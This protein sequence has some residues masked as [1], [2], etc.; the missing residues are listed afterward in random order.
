VNIETI[1]SIARSRRVELF[2]VA[3]TRRAVRSL[4]DDRA[5]KHGPVRV[6]LARAVLGLGDICYVL[7]SALIPN[8]K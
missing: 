5:R 2:E 3:A 4:P 7:G 8:A 1:S 6:A